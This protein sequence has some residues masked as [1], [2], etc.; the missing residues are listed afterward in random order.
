MM[1]FAVMDLPQPDSPTMQTISRSATSSDTCWMAYWRSPPRGSAMVRSRTDNK[2]VFAA[3]MITLPRL[4][5]GLAHVRIQGI[6]EAAAD[7]VDRQHRQQNG[8]TG[9]DDHP[10][11]LPDHGARGTNHEAPAHHVAIAQTQKRQRRFGQNGRGHH[12]RGR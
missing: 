10:R 11:R 3:V 5:I 6:A 8:Q 1:V 2:D 12:E 7:Q 4:L 9:P